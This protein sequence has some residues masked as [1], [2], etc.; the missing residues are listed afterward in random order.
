M[1]DHAVTVT[2]AGA[3]VESRFAAAWLL[4]LVARHAP[5]VVVIEYVDDRERFR[6]REVMF[7]TAGEAIIYARHLLNHHDEVVTAL[8]EYRFAG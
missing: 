2:L 8:I 1:T 7:A 5:F 3:Y 6:T 4:R